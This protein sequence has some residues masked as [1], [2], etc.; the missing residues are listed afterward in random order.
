MNEPLRIVIDN[1]VWISAAL[2]PSSDVGAAVIRAAEEAV[3]IAAKVTL[4]ELAKTLAKPKLSKRLTEADRHRVY[5]N[6]VHLSRI[7]PITECGITDCRHPPD[8][9][10]LELAASAN[11]DIIMTG[12]NDL[13]VLHPWRG[14][15]ILSPLQFLALPYDA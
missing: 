13:L 2:K 10:F 11:V 1:N 12:D 9:K 14:I 6:A 15:A 4:D 7:M 5:A 3:I 8:N